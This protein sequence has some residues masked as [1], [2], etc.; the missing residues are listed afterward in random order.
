MVAP[1]V[2]QAPKQGDEI[3]DSKVDERLELNTSFLISPPKGSIHIYIGGLPLD[4]LLANYSSTLI[5]HRL[6]D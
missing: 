1:V 5:H 4:L 2:H 6:K 3:E